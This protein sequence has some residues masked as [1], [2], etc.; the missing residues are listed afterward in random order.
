[1]CND[2]PDESAWVP[3]VGRFSAQLRVS[4]QSQQRIHCNCKKIWILVFYLLMS[5]GDKQVPGLFCKDLRWLGLDTRVRKDSITD[6]VGNLA[7]L[8]FIAWVPVRPRLVSLY[9][10][11]SVKFTSTA[12]CLQ[13]APSTTWDCSS[14]KRKGGC[15]SLHEAFVRFNI[16]QNASFYHKFW[17]RR[18]P[19]MELE[20]VGIKPPQHIPAVYY[21]NFSYVCVEYA[22]SGLAYLVPLGAVWGQRSWDGDLRHMCPA[23]N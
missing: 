8:L 22:I 2:M 6:T 5:T 23:C 12:C 15:A 13:Y 7:T 20:S 19:L 11:C 18:P 1:M 14:K 3:I 9:C 17:V 4:K 16:L 10:A 21:C